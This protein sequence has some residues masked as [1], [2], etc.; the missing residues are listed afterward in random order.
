MINT[1]KEHKKALDCAG[2]GLQNCP[3]TPEF[4]AKKSMPWSEKLTAIGRHKRQIS[5]IQPV[6]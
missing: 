6:I 4:I 3:D 2:P 5:V 1:A